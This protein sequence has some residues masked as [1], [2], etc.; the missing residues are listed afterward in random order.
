MKNTNTCPKC[1]SQNIVKIPSNKRGLMVELY[2]RYLCCSCGFTEQYCENL[3]F[4]KKII[5]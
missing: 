3:Q 2:D 5:S 1:N 4:M